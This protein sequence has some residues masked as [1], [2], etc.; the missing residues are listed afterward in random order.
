MSGQ[1][2]TQLVQFQEA[3]A[4]GGDANA[5]LQVGLIYQQGFMGHPPDYLEAVRRFREAG[6]DS[7]FRISI[8]SWIT[9]FLL[10]SEILRFQD[11][12]W[13][14]FATHRY[15]RNFSVLKRIFE[16]KFCVEQLKR[17]DKLTPCWLRIT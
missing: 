15:L 2:A 1:E 14:N 12:S 6:K 16:F 17:M 13:L 3:L 9:L 4:D 11:F 8:C 5:Q 10:F 7:Q